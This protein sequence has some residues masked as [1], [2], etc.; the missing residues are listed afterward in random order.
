MAVACV[1]QSEVQEPW[2]GPGGDDFDLWSPAASASPPA[3]LLNQ[4]A[5]SLPSHNL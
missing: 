4:L 5:L 1:N 3:S 2:P